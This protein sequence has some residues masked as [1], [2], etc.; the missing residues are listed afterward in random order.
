MPTKRNSLDAQLAKFVKHAYAHAPAV[1][2]ILDDARIK[3]TAIKRVADLERVPVTSKD[4]LVELQK[5]NP[6]FGGFLAANPKTL[7]HIFLSPGPLYEPGGSEKAL[8]KTAAAVFRAAGFKRGDVVLNTLSYHL[9]PAGLL[10]DAGLQA[11]GATVVMDARP[12]GEIGTYARITD[13]EGNVIG[14]WQDLK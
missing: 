5:Q 2:K 4:K 6:P 7:K 1:R 13:T 10:L 11:A 14:V 8:L 9:V 12:V 3:P